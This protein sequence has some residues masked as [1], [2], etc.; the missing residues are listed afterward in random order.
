MTEYLF[1][2]ESLETLCLPASLETLEDDALYHCRNLKTIE[3]AEGSEH[4]TAAS[5]LA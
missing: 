5:S 1:G 4:F 3:V 2:L